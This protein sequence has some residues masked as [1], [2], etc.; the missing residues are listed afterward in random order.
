MRVGQLELVKH[1][2]ELYLS[3]E[4]RTLYSLDCLGA[5]YS[6][7]IV[8]V[9][10]I[11]L[12]KNLLRVVLR[13]LLDCE[14]SRGDVS[15]AFPVQREKENLEMKEIKIILRSLAIIYCK[16]LYRFIMG[17]FVKGSNVSHMAK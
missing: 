4:Y 16:V 15:F 8:S 17:G 9:C 11:Y 1:L 3:L 10:C 6:A 2:Y 12:S 5:C 14:V 7:F 13:S